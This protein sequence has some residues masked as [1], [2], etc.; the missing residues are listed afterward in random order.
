M[1]TKERIEK[2]NRYGIAE[3]RAH[4]GE[5]VDRVRFT[6]EPIII[7]KS[8]KSAVMVLPLEPSD[9]ELAM[10]AA[11]KKRMWAAIDRIRQHVSESGVSQEEIEELVAEAVEWARNNPE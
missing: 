4:L 11:S 8:G 7:E 10:R 2:R 3:A 9:E 5:I 6:G 1:A